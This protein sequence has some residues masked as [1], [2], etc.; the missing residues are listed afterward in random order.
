MRSTAP[1]R[2]AAAAVLLLAAADAAATTAR[3]R[4]L[5][6]LGDFFEDDAN[7]RRWYGSLVD[8]PQRAVLELGDWDLDAGGSI[9]RRLSRQ[10]G[11]LHAQFD[12]EQRWGVAAVYFGE[13]LPLPDGGG[14]VNL[15]YARR[16]GDV[17]V[18]GSFYASSFSDAGSTHVGTWL[19]GRS[20]FVHELGLG[21]RWDLARHTY[22]DV[23]AYRRHVEVDYF[24]RVDSVVILMP[25]VHGW[26]SFGARARV[27]HGLTEQLA[28]V[29]RIDYVRDLRFLVD[30]DLNDLARQDADNLALG[31][32]L[33]YLPDPDNLIVVSLDYRRVDDVRR[34]RNP[35]YATF[36]HR[37]GDWWRLDGR[38]GLE[39]RVLPWLTVRAAVSYRRTVDEFTLTY[40]WSDEFLE[41]RYDYRVHVSTPVVLGLGVHLGAF[42]ADLV[43]NDTAPFGPG[44]PPTTAPLDGGSRYSAVTLGYRF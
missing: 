3:Q 37:Q 30:P 16:F 20:N 27:F 8:Y 1:V 42:D 22:L 28:A 11:G 33:N 35:F 6:G 23:A 38:C 18:G 34:A 13:D 41:W 25:N 44:F 7:V 40:R 10:G 26:D 14:W 5:G 4:S 12:A 17:S 43:L 24:A 2:L 29:G 31:A 36:Q 15:L 32:G 9:S 39:S 19:E 21:A